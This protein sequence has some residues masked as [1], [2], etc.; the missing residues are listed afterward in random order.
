[1]LVK[2]AMGN[3]RFAMRACP[4]KTRHGY[5]GGITQITEHSDAP[6]GAATFRAK[7]GNTPRMASSKLP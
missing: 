6:G 4:Q 7:F 1:M 2:T 3:H 5:F